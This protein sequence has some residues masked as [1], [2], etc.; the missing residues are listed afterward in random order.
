MLNETKL[1]LQ[2]PWRF[3]AFETFE[4]LTVKIFPLRMVD[5]QPRTLSWG[6]TSE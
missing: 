1:E 5:A 4:I 3:F 6:L 2:V